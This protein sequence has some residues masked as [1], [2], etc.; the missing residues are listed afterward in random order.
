MKIDDPNIR[1][2]GFNPILKMNFCLGI[3]FTGEIFRFVV[4]CA[5]YPYV[6]WNMMLFAATSAVGQVRHFT[7]FV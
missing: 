3:L 4:F 5:R 2:N 1:T 6:L 7:S